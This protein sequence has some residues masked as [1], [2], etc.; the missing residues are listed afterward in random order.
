MTITAAERDARRRDV[1]AAAHSSAMEGLEAT[2]E[3]RAD[4]EAYVDGQFDVD[5]LVRR[6]RARYGLA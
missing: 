6:T 3:Y 1:A 4:A 2:A 5:E